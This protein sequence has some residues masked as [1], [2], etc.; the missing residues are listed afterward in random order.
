MRFVT[1]IALVL[2]SHSVLAAE[3]F[4]ISVSI[5]RSTNI[6]SSVIPS[7]RMAYEN[8]ISKKRCFDTSSAP[9]DSSNQVTYV[10]GEQLTSREYG[11][12]PIDLARAELH[13][14]R[15]PAGTPGEYVYDF[16]I[17]VRSAHVNTSA[18]SGRVFSS[19][20]RFEQ[21]IQGTSFDL[22]LFGSR[23]RIGGNPADRASVTPFVLIA[24]C[25]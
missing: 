7:E 18:Y 17:I 21:R 5:G 3:P 12:R 15:H 20:D 22:P 14:M 16:W 25:N 8:I 4:K 24:N 10:I 1:S 9:F 19:S 11:G 6:F 13:L 23:A 2:L